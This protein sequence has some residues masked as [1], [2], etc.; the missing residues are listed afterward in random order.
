MKKYFVIF[1][2][3]V[4]FFILTTERGYL[5]PLETNNN[6][7][8]I[9]FIDVEQGDC[10]FITLPTGENILID[11]GSPSTGPK[12]TQYLKS[13]SVK[14]IDHLI[15]THPHDDHIGGIFSILSEF[16]VLNFYDNGFSN[17]KSD[18][19][20]DY[21]KSIRKDLS[22]YN[23]LQAGE[24]LLFSNVKIKVLN[25]LLP[26]TGDLN[27]DSI[28]LRLIYEDVKILLTGDLGQLGERRLLKLKTDLVSQIL[29]IA[30]HGEDDSSSYDFLK[31]V[32]PEVAIISVSKINKY[33]RPHQNVLNRLT[34]VG[35]KIYRTDLNGNIVLRI[36]GK[37]YSIKTGK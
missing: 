15:L 10:T 12:I 27:T 33:A 9:H 36:D 34:Q 23:I 32:K 18:I 29:K 4:F 2:T 21:I 25:P 19:Y 28:V 8:I 13:L 16:K 37:T 17:F 22:K 14:K 35:A 30:H 31:N 24:S 11:A 7:V 3:T 6:E 1:I 5:T 26:P 20:R